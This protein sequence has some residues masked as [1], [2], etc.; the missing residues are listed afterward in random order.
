[1]TRHLGRGKAEIK[2]SERGKQIVEMRSFEK[3]TR[4]AKGNARKSA[5]MRGTR[6]L[7]EILCIDE[8]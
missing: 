7:P 6:P 1:M 3:K 5:V 4:D 8:N 2:G